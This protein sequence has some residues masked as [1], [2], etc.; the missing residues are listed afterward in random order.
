MKVLTVTL[1]LLASGPAL[2]VSDRAAAQEYQM[3]SSTDAR[4]IPSRAKH[5]GS[6]GHGL[7]RS[8]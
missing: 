7:N 4:I 2:L 8:L 1:A 3:F 5:A 6:F